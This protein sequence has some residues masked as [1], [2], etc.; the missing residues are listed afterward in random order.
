MGLAHGLLVLAAVLVGVGV[1]QR[2]PANTV[3]PDVG[4][5]G[6]D[7]WLLMS[8]MFVAA[9]ARPGHISVGTGSCSGLLS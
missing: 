6:G 9:L 4:A 5:V 3:D 1:L 8:A 2:G 7:G